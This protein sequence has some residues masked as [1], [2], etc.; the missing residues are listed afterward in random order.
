MLVG[1]GKQMSLLKAR[2]MSWSSDT[3]WVF[4]HVNVLYKPT[5]CIDT[6][7]AAVLVSGKKA[8]IYFI[9]ACFQ[10][11]GILRLHFMRFLVT[12]L[13]RCKPNLPAGHKWSNPNMGEMTGSGRLLWENVGIL[14]RCGHVWTV[15][16]SGKQSQGHHTGNIKRGLS[17]N[18]LMSTAEHNKRMWWV[19][20]Q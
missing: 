13:I 1:V 12:C 15:C 7:V 2:N 17:N 9:K 11:S 18:R 5:L 16:R 8:R 4:I 3:H 6:F 19:H 20:L 10:Y 14:S